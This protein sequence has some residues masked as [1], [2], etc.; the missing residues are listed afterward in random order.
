MMKQ[1]ADVSQQQ[2]KLACLIMCTSVLL[3]VDIRIM[4]ISKVASE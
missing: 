2:G 4:S 1:V 3:H